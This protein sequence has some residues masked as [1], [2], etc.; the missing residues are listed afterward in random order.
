MPEASGDE[1]VD[2]VEAEEAR[3]SVRG[4]VEACVTR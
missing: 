3:D 4:A 1:G 2:A